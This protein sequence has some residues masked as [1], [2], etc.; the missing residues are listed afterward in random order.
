MR[1]SVG[2]RASYTREITAD[3]IRAFSD[4]SGDRNPLH[5]DEEYA[6]S[7]VFGRVVAQGMLTASLISTVLGTVLPGP[8]SVYLE[9]YLKFTRP[10]YPGD[11]VTAEVEVT[12]VSEKGNRA[13][14]TLRTT[15]TNQRGEVVIDGWA[16]VL[17]PIGD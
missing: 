5:H 7:T 17:V 9:Q 8:G 2:Q 10:V 11:V 13:F 16:K 14:V 15:C 1:V 3:M 4:L 12:E 6:K